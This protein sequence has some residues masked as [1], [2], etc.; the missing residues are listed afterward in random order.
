MT[1]Y[2]IKEHPILTPQTELPVKFSWQGESLTAQPGEM[3][4]SALFAHGIRIFGQHHKDGA[5]QGIYCANGQCSQCMVLADGKPVKACMT[6]VKR[7]MQVEPLESLPELP[8]VSPQELKTPFE[9]C[10]DGDSAGVDSG[11]WAGGDV[12][13]YPA[14]RV[15]GRD[16]PGR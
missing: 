2:R 8:P 10:G 1:E 16:A 3:I 4:A 12:S 13:R 7:G 9:D 5:P 11:W 6:P 14:G 15:W